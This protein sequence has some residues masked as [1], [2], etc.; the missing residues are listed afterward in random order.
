MLSKSSRKQNKS[1]WKSNVVYREREQPEV[2]DKQIEDAVHKIL[3]L[4]NGG[5]KF[6][7]NFYKF[8]QT[9]W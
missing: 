7:V 8:C 4:E 1:R 5:V 6:L 3:F 2:L 9:S